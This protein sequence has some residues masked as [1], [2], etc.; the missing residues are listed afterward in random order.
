MKRVTIFRLTSGD[1]PEVDRL[2][3]GAK[4]PISFLCK[5]SEVTEYLDIG[6]DIDI[7]ALLQGLA[8]HGLVMPVEDAD[9][10]SEDLQ[11]EPGIYFSTLF[12]EVE[13]EDVE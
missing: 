11:D 3:A 4:F 5:D 7:D 12:D 13:V 8:L 2:M 10:L 1:Y 6:Y 9:R